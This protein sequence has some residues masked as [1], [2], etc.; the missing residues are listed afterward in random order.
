[1]RVSLADTMQAQACVD[2]HNSHPL[3]PKNDW[4]L[5]Q[6]RGVL[7]VTMAMD[8]MYA[9]S[10][11]IKWLVVF[12]GFIILL[13]FTATLYI[14]FDRIVL[15]R[16]KMLNDSLSELARGEGN[17]SKSLNITGNDEISEVAEQFNHFLSVF[18]RLISSTVEAS[19]ALESSVV[20]AKI[21]ATEIHRKLDSQ[22]EQTSLMA[23]SVNQVACSIE[24]INRNAQQAAN[25]TQLADQQLNASNQGMVESVQNINLLHKNMNETVT[26]I[27]SVSSQSNDIGSVLDVI[28]SIAEQTNLLA[29]NA[30]I[31]AARAGEQGRGFAVVADEVRALAHRTQD[32]IA[33]IQSTVESLQ[34]LGVD[35]MAKVQQGNLQTT[36]TSEFIAT[37]ADKLATAI[38]YENGV[39]VA[40][41]SIAAAMEEQSTVSVDI[42]KNVVKLR[43]LATDSLAELEHVV[44]QLDSVNT[45]ADNLSSALSKFEV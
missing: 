14:L 33:Q 37:V 20:K 42:D 18:R 34:K 3:T 45:Q 26:V 44:K 39:N 11:H 22:E 12:G 25:N 29:L 8:E 4:Q 10:S 38:E 9:T 7:E 36:Q 40:V 17:L 15:S 23:T 21:A 5:N 19:K 1:M 2:C 35:A 32:S 27:A 13:I 41:S 6:V 31:E 43:D 16:T 24:D 30:A 28:K